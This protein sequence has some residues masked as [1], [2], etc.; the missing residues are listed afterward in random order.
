M[1]PLAHID[2]EPKQT[3]QPARFA[4]KKRRARALRRPKS[5]SIPPFS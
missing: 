4:R 2:H 1:D 5:A 3:K